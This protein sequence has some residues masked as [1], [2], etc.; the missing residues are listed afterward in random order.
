[1]TDASSIA[2]ILLSRGGA[3][4]AGA[5]E[6][7]QLAGDV[8]AALAA[9][10][11]APLL[12]QPAFTDRLRPALPEALDACVAAQTVV[13][14]PVMAPDEPS[15]LRWLH[16]LAMRWRAGRADC[17]RLVFADPLLQAPRLPAMLACTVRRSLALP[18]VPAVVGDDA[19]ERDPVGWSS[20]PGHQHHVLWCMGPRCAAKG[21]V[22]LWPQ[23]AQAVRDSPDLRKRVMLLQTSC[24]YP[25]NH[26]P[27]MIVY[28]DG[29]WY[30]PLAGADIGRVLGRHVL[31]GQVD[32][33]LRVHGP[34]TLA[35][36]C[37]QEET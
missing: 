19:W 16:K 32:E 2:V 7:A 13:I 20:V 18:D 25:C 4:S 9:Q 1:M 35:E 34:Q 26:G 31:Q 23:L 29:V 5:S 28:P 37:R 14:V 10:G 24:Q 11:M 3:Y 33:A 21:A 15:L 6:L 27:L 12:V 8:H 30:G 36:A 17:P 22:Q